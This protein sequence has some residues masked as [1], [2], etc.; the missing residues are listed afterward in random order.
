MTSSTFEGLEHAVDAVGEALVRQEFAVGRGRR[1]EAVGHADAGL[2]EVADHFAQEA[3]LPPT[4]STSAMP[5]SEYHRT[6][7]LI[8]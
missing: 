6:F 4:I 1:R 5:S 8:R 7:L 3:F 2:G